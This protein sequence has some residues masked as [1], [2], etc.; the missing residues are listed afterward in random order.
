M[1]EVVPKAIIDIRVVYDATQCGLNDA[2]WAPNFFLPTVDS[3]LRNASS[4]T[5]FGDID[6][7]E[8]FL[9]YALDMDI[10]MYAGVDV[11]EQVADVA[12]G[13][14]RVLDE[15]W[16][17]TL[18]GLRSSP[19]VCTQTFAWSEEIIMGDHLEISN[20]FYWDKVILNLPGTLEYDPTMLVTIVS[21]CEKSSG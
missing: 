12:A 19:F 20:P 3:I 15:R 14:K 13:A 8:M 1:E 2:L 11:T 5:W 9:N 18:M 4:S 16:T 17:R 6:L 10:R 7:G 21:A